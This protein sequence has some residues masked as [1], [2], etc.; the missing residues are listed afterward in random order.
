MTYLHVW[1]LRSLNKL[2]GASKERGGLD[3]GPL[4]AHMPGAGRHRRPPRGHREH[5]RNTV[6]FLMHDRHARNPYEK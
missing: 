3:R 6:R 5:K 2:V 1:L 4:P